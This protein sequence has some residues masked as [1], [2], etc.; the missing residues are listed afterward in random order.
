LPDAFFIHSSS[1]WRIVWP[2]YWIAKST[3][4][5]V[6][7][8]AAAMVPVSKSSVDVGAAERHVEMG[9]DVDAAGH[10][11]LARGVD[12]AVRLVAMGREVAADGRDGAVLT[13]DVGDVVVRRR[14]HAP[15][16]DERDMARAI[17]P[18]NRHRSRRY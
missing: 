13:K 12:G 10:D 16:G 3:R 17:L 7:P 4:Q 18:Q 14:N 2:R 1:A 6:P 5:V 11:V 8:K 9:V 15:V